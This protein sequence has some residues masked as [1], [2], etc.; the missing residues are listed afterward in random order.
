M[1]ISASHQ[2]LYPQYSDFLLLI[3]N[4][5]KYINS[6][7][8]IWNNNQKVCLNR[9]FDNIN[10][11]SIEKSHFDRIRINVPRSKKIS[12][13]Y[14]FANKDKDFDR[15]CP[16]IQDKIVRI[17]A[18]ITFLWLMFDDTKT[19]AK[20]FYQSDHL[21]YIFKNNHIEIENTIYALEKINFTNKNAYIPYGCLIIPTCSF[22]LV[23]GQIIS[24]TQEI[25]IGPKTYTV[26]PNF[27]IANEP[28]YTLTPVRIEIFLTCPDN[29]KKILEDIDSI[30]E[31]LNKK[32]I[33]GYQSNESPD[34]VDWEDEFNTLFD[35]PNYIRKQNGFN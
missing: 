15:L 27:E 9:I 17:Y 26:M 16:N 25:I 33:I 5:N 31:N 1:G 28:F 30:I 20:Y 23:E 13:V 22:R 10:S 24:N 3:N 29:L 7:T 11:K 2:P 14:R 18:I 21:H 32:E 19:P 8:Q 4:A 35:D 12:K 34:Q 6:D